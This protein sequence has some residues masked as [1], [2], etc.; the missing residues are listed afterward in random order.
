[1]SR[2]L[3]LVY[4]ALLLVGTILCLVHVSHEQQQLTFFSNHDTKLIP[5]SHNMT[6][7]DPSC[8]TISLRRSGSDPYQL[9]PDV[10]GTISISFV[11]VETTS[12]VSYRNWSIEIMGEE[13]DV[14]LL[15]Q[16]RSTTGNALLVWNARFNQVV[17]S[18][19]SVLACLSLSEDDIA[20][21]STPSLLVM[22]GDEWETQ[23][24]SHLTTHLQTSSSLSS[25][26]GN[27]FVAFEETL[28]VSVSYRCPL[29]HIESTKKLSPAFACES[30]P[31]NSRRSNFLMERCICMDG[32][33]NENY[34]FTTLSTANGTNQIDSGI[35]IQSENS[36][37]S[38]SISCVSCPTGAQCIYD[39]QTNNSTVLPMD[40]YYPL[41]A[42]V[43]GKTVHKFVKCVNEDA[44]KHQFF[45]DQGRPLFT[46]DESSSYYYST[47][48]I[49]LLSVTAN[50]DSSSSNTTEQG[51]I[52]GLCAAGYKGYMCGQCKSGF[53]KIGER[54]L[55]CGN[56]HANRTAI[57][58]YVFGLLVIWVLL[59]PMSW[60]NTYVPSF[61][62]LLNFIQISVLFASFHLN[63]DGVILD[64]LATF[65]LLNLN[66]QTLRTECISDYS[67]F[68]EFMVM[69]LIPVGYLLGLIFIMLL[70]SMIFIMCRYQDWDPWK[71]VV[72]YSTGS[73]LSFIIH[74]GS[75]YLFQWIFSFQSCEAS[76]VGTHVRRHYW[77]TDIICSRKKS[78]TF[79]AYEVFFWLALAIYVIIVCFLLPLAV[80]MALGLSRVINQHKIMNKKEKMEQ[81]QQQQQSNSE[82]EIEN[83][84]F[85]SW[86]GTVRAVGWLY[87]RYKRNFF[88][89]EII[90]LLRKIL[91]VFCVAY[92]PMR[93]IVAVVVTSIIIIL[94][95]ASTLTAFPY[96]R[97]TSTL[98]DAF[99]LILQ[100]LMLILG[101]MAYVSD[102]DSFNAS[103]MEMSRSIVLT[104]FYVGIVVGVIVFIIELAMALRSRIV[105]LKAGE[106][107]RWDF[108]IAPS[109]IKAGLRQSEEV[110]KPSASKYNY[111]LPLQ[112][113]HLATTG[114]EEWESTL[115]TPTAPPV[116]P[117]AAPRAPIAAPPPP[118]MP[119]LSSTISAPSN[120]SG[121]PPPP[122]P[123]PP[124]MK[125][126]N[127]GLA[128]PPPSI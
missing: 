17:E 35:I 25:S 98:L 90:V 51:V 49:S 3:Y 2:L 84:T 7:L 121:G 82:D 1:M 36:D 14:E 78:V 57:A 117:P 68:G 74:N 106:I 45:D 56:L 103:Y 22:G 86:P 73:I 104:T 9:F 37:D 47:R 34:L 72:Q 81:Q 42:T 52:N 76:S 105:A 18:E 43:K 21:A 99:L 79:R 127:K 118:P 39:L 97:V 13:G 102:S 5:L 100:Y 115:K 44:C 67:F 41:V 107:G 33:Y 20:T 53:F 55:K 46:M 101:L 30:C 119:S 108:D 11:S 24:Q 87:Y 12:T 80:Y 128:P 96:R 66:I 31:S 50:N 4:T 126:L 111:D 110:K 29:T 61:S 58:A 88:F 123:P 120:N 54:C 59:I 114:D 15:E 16:R 91:I 60:L 92:I 26:S 124:P 93:P 65:S 64:N 69:I 85:E 125:L 10:G 32:Y 89:W 71:R 62:V 40:G 112:D 38:S 48:E 113:T 77:S 8:F 94:S 122:P 27:K 116:P 70:V 23:Y 75:V 109:I 83:F 63:W 95:L 19:F 28:A 6:V